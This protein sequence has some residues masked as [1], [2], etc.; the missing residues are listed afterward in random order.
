M[1]ARK[2]RIINHAGIAA[3][4]CLCDRSVSRKKTKG[5]GGNAENI[6][7][8]KGVFGSRIGEEEEVT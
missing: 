7:K 6:P 4:T 2:K 1:P 5:R 3:Q 8:A